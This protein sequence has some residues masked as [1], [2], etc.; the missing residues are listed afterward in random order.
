MAKPQLP[1]ASPD[2]RVNTLTE[3]SAETPASA[4]KINNL[5]DIHCVRDAG[6]RPLQ[7]ATTSEYR[8]RLLRAPATTFVITRSPSRSNRRD[9]FGFS[10]ERSGRAMEQVRLRAS[11]TGSIE[12]DRRAF[13]LDKAFGDA[14]RALIQLKSGDG[15]LISKRKSPLRIFAINLGQEFESFQARH[16]GTKLGTPKP[17]VFA[18]E[19]ATSVRSNSLFDPMMRSSCA[20]TSTR[21]ASARR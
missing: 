6:D 10:E 3:D 7:T 17:A 14:T 19:A 16:F 13:A 18:L 8:H 15:R 20:S 21:W 2:T 1:N 4:L 5:E 9:S 11:V 12:N